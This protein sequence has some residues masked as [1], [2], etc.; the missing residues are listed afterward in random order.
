MEM[1]K[2]IVLEINEVPYKVY[3][4][5]ISKNPTSLLAKVLNESAQYITKS[6]DQGE[7]HPWSTWPTSVRREDTARL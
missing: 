1:R 3:D 7:L 2:L 4:H 6:T 5:F